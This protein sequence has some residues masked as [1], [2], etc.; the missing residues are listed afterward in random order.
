MQ[1]TLET[2]VTLKSNN[3]KN[4]LNIFS[5]KNQCSHSSKIVELKIE[6]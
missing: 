5:K 6:T 3:V 1:P 2:T 4:L